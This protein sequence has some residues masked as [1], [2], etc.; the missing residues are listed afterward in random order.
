[1]KQRTKRLLGI[2][3][4]FIATS[5]LAA[6]APPVHVVTD[7]NAS[8][9]VGSYA[10]AT[11]LLPYFEVD[12]TAQSSKAVNTVFTVINTSK[13]PQIVRVTVW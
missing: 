10:A 7:N 9:D 13:L 4:F 12:Y 6:A 5:G 8:C 2:W 3:Y 1:M 11:L